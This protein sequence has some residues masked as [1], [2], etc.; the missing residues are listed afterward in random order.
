MPTLVLKAMNLMRLPGASSILVRRAGGDQKNSRPDASTGSAPVMDLPRCSPG[1][2]TF[3]TRY[4]CRRVHE[5]VAS[6]SWTKIWWSSASWI[7]AS[8][9]LSR[10]VLIT[11]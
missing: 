8:P 1:A 5:E 2:V 7:S 3:G 6:P 10:V 11:R 4:F 9:G